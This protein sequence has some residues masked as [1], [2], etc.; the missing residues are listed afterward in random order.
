[1]ITL[2]GLFKQGRDIFL[3]VVMDGI[4]NPGLKLFNI[5][6]KISSFFLPKRAYKKLY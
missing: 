4:V 2:I 1:M 5:N 6:K 3:T